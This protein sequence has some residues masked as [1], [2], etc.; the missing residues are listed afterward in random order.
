MHVA[1]IIKLCLLG[2]TSRHKVCLQ[3]EETCHA[4]LGVKL[5]LLTL[6]QGEGRCGVS[7]TQ[8]H[9]SEIFALSTLFLNGKQIFGMFCLQDAK[10]L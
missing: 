6:V 7:F 1:F 2:L 8:Q 9:T 5:R 10:T 3:A 4:S